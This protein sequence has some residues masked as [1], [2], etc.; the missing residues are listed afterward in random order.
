[1]RIKKVGSVY[2]V[3]LL[4]G[5]ELVRSLTTLAVKKRLGGAFF[6]GL[7]VARNL[8]LGYFDAHKKSYV[9]KRFAGE[10]EFTSLVGDISHFDKK[11][12]VHAHAT[13]TDAKFRALGGHVFEAYIPATCEII[14]LPFASK[15]VRMFDPA[16]GLNLLRL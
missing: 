9:K 10:Y 1:M 7:G 11:V 3:R 5:E 4:K 2:L 8:T 13:I 14:V 12:V 15:L 16:T 6:F